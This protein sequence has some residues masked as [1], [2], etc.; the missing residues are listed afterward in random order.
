MYKKP[1]TKMRE[2]MIRE[3]E[4]FLSSGFKPRPIAEAKK[5]GKWGKFLPFGPVG[6][7]ANQEPTG[8]CS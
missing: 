7:K 5:A 6:R 8:L 2:R 1:L 4:E 3:T